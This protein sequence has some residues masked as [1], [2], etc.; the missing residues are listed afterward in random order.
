MEKN[1]LVKGKSAVI[2]V[3]E[4][5]SLGRNSDKLLNMKIYYVFEMRKCFG[6]E[7]KLGSREYSKELKDFP[8]MLK[9]LHFLSPK[10][11]KTKK[12]GKMK[13]KMT[14]ND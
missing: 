2:I 10:N 5:V 13:K 14:L 1:L 4:T 9:N 7:E 12:W 3:K 6:R 11:A 8:K